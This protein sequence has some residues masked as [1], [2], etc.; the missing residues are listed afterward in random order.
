VGRLWQAAGIYLDEHVNNVQVTGNTI[1]NGDWAGIFI[2]NTHDCQI[3]NN[4]IYNH[5]YQMHLSQYSLTSRNM[6]ETG[7]QYIAPKAFQTTWFYRTYVTDSPT[8]MGTSDNN[9]FARP[10]DDNKT[11]RVGFLKNSGGDTTDISLAQWQSQYGLDLASKKS[12]LTFV[13]N[14]NDSIRFEYN[15]SPATKNITLDADYIDVTGASYTGELNLAPWTSVV[16]L[17]SKTASGPVVK[18]AQAINF[19]SIANRTFGD[20][21]FTISASASSGLP[22]SLQVMSG[23]ATVAGNTVSYQW[24]R[25]GR[26]GSNTKRQWGFQPGCSRTANLYGCQGFA[27]PSFRTTPDSY[28]WRCAIYSKRVRFIKPAG[29]VP[30][31][32]GTSH[33]FGQ[34]RYAERNRRSHHR[35]LA[36]RQ[37]QLWG[38]GCRQSKLQRTKHANGKAKPD[39]HLPLASLPHVWQSTV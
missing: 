1:A 3:T 39:H 28:V 26:Y 34:Y 21:P 30:C 31:C 8:N 10:L 4:I 23:P 33:R 15:A 14:I 18:K 25:H 29:V 27:D 5:R 9:Y 20:G 32:I 24:W 38:G 37:C 12:P 17:K 35:G 22:V 36:S 19:P 13:E 6:L 2:H 16:L 7:N 11:I